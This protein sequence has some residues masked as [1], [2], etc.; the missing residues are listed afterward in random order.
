MPSPFKSATETEV[1]AILSRKRHRRAE[2]SVAVAQAHRYVRG[3]VVG[4][5]QIG[6]AVAGKVGDGNR[7]GAG[8]YRAGGH[9]VTSREGE[10]AVAFTHIDPTV[11]AA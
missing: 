4:N 7:T 2:G 9:G 6:D 1:G 8:E 10:L 3:D 11:S 5:D